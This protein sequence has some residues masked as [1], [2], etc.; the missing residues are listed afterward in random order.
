MLRRLT[1]GAL[2]F[3]ALVSVAA[4]QLPTVT[5][6]AKSFEKRDGYFP[7]YWDAA[8]GRLFLEVR[9]GEDFLYL[10]SLAT[11]IGDA[12]LG[13]DRGTIGDEQIG[14]FDRIGP[15]VQLV[16]QNPRF[17]AVS[18]N[19]ALVRSVRE[20]FPLST[21]ASWEIVAEEG[22]RL[23]VD[24]TAYVTSDITDVRGALRTA[25]QGTFALDRDRSAVYLA[26]TKGFP[27]NTEIETTLT[28]TSDNPG[29]SVRR[30]TPDARA[31]TL[32][33]HLSLVRLPAPGFRSRPFDPRM[34]IFSVSFYDFAKPFTEDY[35][36]RYAIRHRLQ[37]RT[38]GAGPSEPIKP[39]VYYLD[40]G[41]PE[42]YRQ[43]FKDGGGWWTRVFE[44][45]GFQ[46]AF[47]VEDMPADMDPLD[48]RYNVI[49]WV[50]RTEPD[51]SIGPSF[52]DPRT[53]EIIKAAVRME[54]HR[55]LTDF[56][57]YA[58]AVPALGGEEAG[59]LDPWLAALAADVTPES[60]AMARRRQH[61]A[62]E[63]GHTLGLAHNFITQAY[64]R[65]SVMDYP[66]PLIKLA[67]GKLDLSDAYRNGPGAWDTL[68][69]RWDY[70]EFTPADE[71]RGLEA[72]A[73]EGIARGLKFITNPDEG[74]SNSYPEATTWVNGRDMTAELQ[75]VMGVRR[76]L[77]DRF[78]ERAIAPGEPMAELNR[79]FAT[80]YL[81]HRFTLGAAIKAVG[82]MEYRYA[83]RGDTGAPTRLIPPAAQ[84]RA[85]ETVLD[86][87]TPRELAVPE[88]V[89]R[90][91][92]PH[93]FGYEIERGFGSAAAPAFDQVG[94]ARTLAASVV[95]GLLEPQRAARLVAFADRDPR[96]P[97]LTE[98]IGRIVDRAWSGPALAEHAALQ[99]VVQRVVVDELIELA[100]RSEAT[101]EVRAAAE[102]GLRRIARQLAAPSRAAGEALAH[103]QLAAAD[104]E[105]FLS[106]RDT[107]TA[108]PQPLAAPP[109]TPIGQ[110]PVPPR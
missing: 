41:I 105:R 67:N 39:I 7:V 49:Q 104:I 73:Q 22:G 8:K 108:R 71:A 12:S 27:D 57:I 80:V 42:P 36:T 53:G 34:G 107:P 78:D 82:G 69:I 61:M 38:P 47:R 60:F 59:D 89:L 106:R 101:P 3:S 9:L 43:A 18:D 30:H 76:F 28:F 14:R 55:S 58:G 21:V 35:V 90:I 72:I 97:S 94:I 96:E 87:I 24:A 52:V 15:K 26:H 92:A 32:R 100:R 51:Y 103:R 45:A 63:I 85:L 29:R 46:N 81:H 65:G 44:A 88:R 40:P 31:L 20:S 102:W 77:L 1:A 6:Y 109:G 50:H 17:R 110:E 62:H 25:N 13:L 83:V 91:L 66:A 70:T 64:G 10:P 95:G 56:D 2:G 93:P 74:S 37:K 75:R 68:A 98:V 11:G 33:Q 79:R 54:S 4:A 48:A 5:E 99:R 84:R 19:E 16:L 86:A 23:L